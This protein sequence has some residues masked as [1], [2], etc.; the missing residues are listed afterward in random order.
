MKGLWG[1]GA[2]F[3]AAALTLCAAA[4]T[5][6]LRAQ[7]D[8]VAYVRLVGARPV[9]TLW[10]MRLD[11]VL[12]FENAA[13]EDVSTF[14]PVAAGTRQLAISAHGD[15]EPV[16]A[17][18][19]ELAAGTF[20]TVIVSGPDA[21]V[22]V[23]VFEDDLSAPDPGTARLRLVHTAPDLGVVHLLATD[24]SPIVEGIAYGEA[25]AYAAADAGLHDLTVRVADTGTDLL[26]ATDLE[27]ADGHVYT[28]FLMGKADGDIGITMLTVLDA[29]PP[30]A[31]S[32]TLYLP[33]LRNR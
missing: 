11:D 24:G 26:T 10:D 28:S 8:E 22:E 12:V 15:G 9:D 6:P 31:P 13:Y 33:A 21:E 32:V 7:G 14:E 5:T 3:F 29:E 18:Q 17:G 4:G 23:H 1:P 27:L 2:M 20:N 30:D 19:V 16:V 25:S